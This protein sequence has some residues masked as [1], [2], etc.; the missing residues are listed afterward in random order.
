MYEY[1]GSIKTVIIARG[2]HKQS[3]PDSSRI[4]CPTRQ[5]TLSPKEER[6]SFTCRTENLVCLGSWELDWTGYVH[7]CLQF[8]SV[9][10]VLSPDF[11]MR[12]HEQK[13]IPC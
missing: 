7:P 8:W 11:S 10:T 6:N 12:L 1:I 2:V 3:D 13:V 9:P 4:L 5:K